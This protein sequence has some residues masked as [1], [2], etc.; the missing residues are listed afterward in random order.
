MVV[1]LLSLAPHKATSKMGRGVART[2]ASSSFAAET[3]AF[4]A[5]GVT[6]SSTWSIRP[7]RDSFF[8]ELRPWT[9]KEPTVHTGFRSTRQSRRARPLW[10]KEK[11]ST[12]KL[13][14]SWAVLARQQGQLA[15]V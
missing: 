10:A 15:L 13:S 3:E 7:F 2:N 12:E 9:L 14:S 11:E 1:A 4:T 5:D 6:F 8:L